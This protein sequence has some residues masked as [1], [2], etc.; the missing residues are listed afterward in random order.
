[1]DARSWWAT[2]VQAAVV[3]VPFVAL[4]ILPELARVSPRSLPGD[5]ST[6]ASAPV[7]AV[8]PALTL[9]RRWQRQHTFIQRQPLMLYWGRGGGPGGCI[10]T[11]GKLA[12]ENFGTVPTGSAYR[13]HWS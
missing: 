4:V 13:Q 8:A 11:D 2:L 9:A 1:M 7:P 5:A 6:L 3:A 12:A 10:F